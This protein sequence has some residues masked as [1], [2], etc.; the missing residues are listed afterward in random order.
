MTPSSL[1]Y[2][3]CPLLS[4]RQ[5]TKDKSKKIKEQDE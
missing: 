2:A 4:K 3:L 5:K 1:P